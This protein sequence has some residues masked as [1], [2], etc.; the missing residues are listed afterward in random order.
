MSS[1]LEAVKDRRW[2]TTVA[3]VIVPV[4]LAAFA[5][6]YPGATVSQVD[7]NDGAVWVT[8]DSALKLGRYNA[9]VGE[10]NS[11]L[12]A[13]QRGFDVVQDGGDV[14][15]VDGGAVGIVDPAAVIQTG[16]ATVPPG[17]SVGLGS[18]VVSVTDSGR[19]WVRSM[20]TLPSLDATT[21]EPDADLGVGGLAVTADSGRVLAVAPDGTVRRLTLE[22]TG[23]EASDA[24]TLDGTGALDQLTAVGDTPVAMSGTTLR[25]PEATVELAAYGTDLVLQQVGPA[26]GAVLVASPLALLSVDLASG[27]VREERSGGSGTPAAPVRLA[28]C[29]Y[30]AWS[31]PTTNFL[32][33]CPSGS[34]VSDL[35]QVSSGD[36][37]MFRTNRDVLVLNNLQEGRIWSPTLDTGAREPNWDDITPQDE[38]E[39][40]DTI[41]DQPGTQTLQSECTAQSGPPTATDDAFGVRGGRTTILSVIDNDVSSDCGILAITEI[42]PLPA[43]FG[44]AVK[45][46]GGRA[47]QLVTEPDASGT[48]TFTYTV[49]DGRG[50]S[51]PSTATV[52]LTIRSEDENN[53]PVQRYVGELAVELGAYGTYNV[54]ADFLDPDGDQLVLMSATVEEAPAPIPAF[55]PPAPAQQTVAAPA[56]ELSD[57]EA[58]RLIKPVLREI[59]LKSRKQGRGRA[60]KAVNSTAAFTL[61]LDHDRH[62]KLR[63]ACAVHNVSAQK[64]ITEAVDNLFDSMPEIEPL[65]TRINAQ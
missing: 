17:A 55:A 14:L 7:L 23:V 10:L 5:L 15:L 60:R 3:A 31:S 13:V 44:T 38:E 37:L 33:S 52:T 6:V 54:L 39:P 18:G 42:D 51:A 4:A 36:E 41:A 46:Y 20:A 22:E 21:T 19:V 64:L 40:G 32:Q 61:R 65:I 30:A 1:L 24:G 34:T 11:G 57:A 26:D 53:A 59:T 16:T 25:T 47:I 62:L 49:T 2:P 9:Q 8:N 28:G 45:I 50:S 48:V 43:T 12:V 27:D 56:I 35:E 29:G 58:T 63:L